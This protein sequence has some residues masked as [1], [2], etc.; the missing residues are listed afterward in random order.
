MQLPEPAPKHIHGY[1]YICPEFKN[2]PNQSAKDNFRTHYRWSGHS[3]H[4]AAV[5]QCIECL[6]TFRDRARLHEHYCTRARNLSL[7]DPLIFCTYKQRTPD[8]GVGNVVK[9]LSALDQYVICFNE[10]LS[11]SK[12]FPPLWARGKYRQNPLYL[13]H[14]SKKSTAFMVAALTENYFKTNKNGLYLDKFVE[15]V[16][17]GVTK[18]RFTSEYTRPIH[19]LLKVTEKGSKYF[20]QLVNEPKAVSQVQLEF[21]TDDDSLVY[22]GYANGSQFLPHS[23][24]TKETKDLN[25][26]RAPEKTKEKLL[27]NYVGMSGKGLRAS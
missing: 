17:Q 7:D 24:P 21:K 20:V 10:K 4:E 12:I 27:S 15:V 22:Q 1:C 3:V 8:F 9:N 5:H 6:M 11:V 16:F 25:L 18:Y 19:S 14:N 23:Y 26:F 13:E 2:L